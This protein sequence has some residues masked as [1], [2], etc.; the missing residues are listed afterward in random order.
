MSFSICR[1]PR[2]AAGTQWLDRNREF[3][4]NAG[5]QRVHAHHNVPNHPRRPFQSS[6]MCN[7]LAT[8]LA[9]RTEW[10]HQELDG[11]GRQRVRA[12][13]K[14][15]CLAPISP[16]K[17]F[18]RVGGKFERLWQ[19][20]SKQASGAPTHWLKLTRLNAAETRVPEKKGCVSTKN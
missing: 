9:A 5:G 15:G 7:Q 1:P 18:E 4:D 19:P 16:S 11:T 3:E 8:S 17:Y 6:T 14:V 10:N 20:A 13:Q 2:L 12:P